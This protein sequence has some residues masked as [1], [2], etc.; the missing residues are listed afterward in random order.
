MKLSSST[1]STTWSATQRRTTTTTIRYMSTPVST[2]SSSLRTGRSFSQLPN[3]IISQSEY[4]VR[5]MVPKLVSSRFLKNSVP[6]TARIRRKMP[7]IKK[8]FAMGRMDEP[9]A[10]T[11]RLRDSNLPASRKIRKARAPERYS[12]PS[13]SAELTSETITMQKSKS[14]QGFLIKAKNQWTYMLSASSRAK[15]AVKRM[16]KVCRSSYTLPHRSWLGSAI[17]KGSFL[18]RGWIWDSKTTRKKLTTMV[19]DRNHWYGREL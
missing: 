19:V 13:M 12:R 11:M 15:K 14:F 2:V 8:A 18:G 16:S 10:D 1:A 6:S 9:S 7:P 4:T 3:A 17:Q 5:N